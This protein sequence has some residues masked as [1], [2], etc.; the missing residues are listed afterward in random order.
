MN[1]MLG[2]LVPALLGVDYGWQQKPDG[3]I[4]YIVQVDAETFAEMQRSGQSIGSALPPDVRGLISDFSFRIGREPLPNQ[5][6]LPTV[7]IS[8]GATPT[9][10]PI[11]TEAAKPIAA[12]V[13]INANYPPT[14]DIPGASTAPA[15]STVTSPQPTRYNW[16]GTPPSVSI[17]QT[18]A[19][20]G[21]QSW[22]QNT[23]PA[24]SATTVPSVS[25]SGFPI[26]PT[27]APPNPFPP[28]SSTATSGAYPNSTAPPSLNNG[29]RISQP[30][31]WQT[32]PREVTISARTPLE[33]NPPLSSTNQPTGPNLGMNPPVMPNSNGY[34]TGANQPGFGTNGY[35]P[36]NQGYPTGPQM[37]PANM[38]PQYATN[39]YP[40][41]NAPPQQNYPHQQGNGVPQQN[42]PY[43]AQRQAQQ[44]QQ[45]A[46]RE[47]MSASAVN[48]VGGQATTN[49]AAKADDDFTVRVALLLIGFLTS[50]A[51]NFYFGWNSYQLRERCRMLLSDRGAF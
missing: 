30:T 39:N 43:F 19:P 45:L 33:P 49:T 42:D 44:Q 41:N 2:L 21:P 29:P 24:S 12:P 23:V 47:P 16:G 14:S 4:N 32:P 13:R 26:N 31:P 9:P 28:N 37:I 35:P 36:N 27:A 34:P 51:A 8:S 1:V 7:S 15:G 46:Q 48:P 3:T 22:S 6:T 38:P 50:L 18:A 25:T 40:P 20:P 17:P 11:S 5:N 10:D